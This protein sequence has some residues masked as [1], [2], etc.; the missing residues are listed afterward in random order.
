MSKQFSFP[1]KPRK[2][3]M[4]ILKICV[5]Q[6]AERSLLLFMNN[7]CIM[8]LLSQFRVDLVPILVPALE[9][10]A[11]RHWN[12]SVH[13]LTISVRKLVQD[14][15][16]ELYERYFNLYLQDLDKQGNENEERSKTW[17]SLEVEAAMNSL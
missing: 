12:P 17:E 5:F 6:V 1:S 9:E 11:N 7:D 8:G 13:T 3:E 16:E 4:D 10:N 15:D 2:S 14:L